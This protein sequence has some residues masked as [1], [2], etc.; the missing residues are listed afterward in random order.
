[1]LVEVRFAYNSE[2]L[3]ALLLIEDERGLV[4]AKSPADGVAEFWLDRGM[5]YLGWLDE[6]HRSAHDLLGVLTYRVCHG[7]IYRIL[8]GP[9]GSPVSDDEFDQAYEQLLAEHG[10]AEYEYVLRANRGIS[11]PGPP[12]HRL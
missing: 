4:R 10:A 12:A 3:E 8:Q 1:M 9:D 5:E 2:G 7:H 6:S 11:L